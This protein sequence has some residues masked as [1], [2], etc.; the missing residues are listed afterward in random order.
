MHE[1]DTDESNDGGKTDESNDGSETNKGDN[2]SNDESDYGS[3]YGSG[4]EM[5]DNSA[6]EGELDNNWLWFALVLIL[7]LFI[8]FLLFIVRTLLIHPTNTRKC[9]STDFNAKYFKNRLLLLRMVVWIPILDIQ[10]CHIADAL[11]YKVFVCSYPAHYKWH[12]WKLKIIQA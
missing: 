6:D 8:T 9:I 2:E 4:N 5:E 3:D 7:F 10:V 1:F 11:L 12:T